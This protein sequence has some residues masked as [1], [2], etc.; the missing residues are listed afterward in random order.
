MEFAEPEHIDAALT[1]DNSLLHGRL[2]KVWIT[3]LCH[4][5]SAYNLCRLPQNGQMFPALTAGED[6]EVIEVDTEAGI[7]VTVAI[8]HIG[9]VEGAFS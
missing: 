2:I 8:L 9:L 7:G 4:L 6:V 3:Y 5:F 1:M